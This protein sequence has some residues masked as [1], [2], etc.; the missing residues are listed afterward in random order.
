M[1]ED[2]NFST[3][4]EFLQKIKNWNKQGIQPFLYSITYNNEI[5][6]IALEKE[7]KV[8]DNLFNKLQ[9]LVK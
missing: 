3:H 9:N 4:N 6:H 5:F 8:F 1:K 2:I 7:D